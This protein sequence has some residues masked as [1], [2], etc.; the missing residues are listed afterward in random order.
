MDGRGRHE[1]LADRRHET[2]S[3]RFVVANC[4]NKIGITV[5]E[6]LAADHLDTGDLDPDPRRCV[7]EK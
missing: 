4:H 7:I 5:P 2:L 3:A 6:L 1:A